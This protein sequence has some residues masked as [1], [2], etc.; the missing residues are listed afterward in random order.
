MPLELQKVTE[1]EIYEKVKEPGFGRAG[2]TGTPKRRKDELEREGF[3]G[4]MY[5]AETKNMKKAQDKLFASCADGGLDIDLMSNVKEKP[6]HIYA[7]RGGK[8]KTKT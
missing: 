4:T 7:I 8:E 6:G 3:E 1:E 2:H 5:Y